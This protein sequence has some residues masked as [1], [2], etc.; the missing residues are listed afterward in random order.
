MPRE[1]GHIKSSERARELA[2]K[3]KNPGRKRSKTKAQVKEETLRGKLEPEID[4]VV[5]RLVAL[6][7]DEDPAVRLRACTQILDRY[8]GKP[9]ESVELSGPNSGAIPL[10]VAEALL[11]DSLNPD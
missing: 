4:E 2:A 11:D 6:S 7:H 10:T 3:R 9:I 5:N 8:Y 1:D